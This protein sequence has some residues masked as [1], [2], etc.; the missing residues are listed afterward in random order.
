MA[1]L[2]GGSDGANRLLNTWRELAENANSDGSGAVSAS[3][4]ITNVA[5]ASN[6]GLAEKISGATT[7]VASASSSGVAENFSRPPHADS[8][9][10]LIPK[11][12]I[13]NLCL[14][15]KKAMEAMIKLPHNSG[16][17]SPATVLMEALTNHIKIEETSRFVNHLEYVKERFNELNQDGVLAAMLAL[18]ERPIVW[19]GDKLCPALLH[20]A[21]PCYDISKDI[22]ATG[23]MDSHL[24]LAAG[25]DLSSMKQRPT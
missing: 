8:S 14:A 7:S 21:S 20:P 1:L 19:D 2:V 4:A 23:I 10:I 5:S 15:L 17:L 24:I 16:L 12:G 13:P 3:D 25:S 22:K 9:R 18:F 6:S 11:L